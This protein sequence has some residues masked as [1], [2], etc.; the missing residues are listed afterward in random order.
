MHSFPVHHI[1]KC[2]GSR[3]HLPDTEIK[4]PDEHFHGKPSYCRY[5]VQDCNYLIH[6]LSP[7]KKYIVLYFNYFPWGSKYLYRLSLYL[8]I[9]N[10]FEIIFEVPPCIFTNRRPITPILQF[11]G[12][13][14]VLIY[15]HFMIWHS[16]GLRAHFLSRFDG[17]GVR[18][19]GFDGEVPSGVVRRGCPV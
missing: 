4:V 6:I 15:D 18:L 5:K 9:R 13:C 12:T 19:C 16:F 14:Y 1:R 3:H 2:C 11:I 17:G 7:I 10:I 8:R